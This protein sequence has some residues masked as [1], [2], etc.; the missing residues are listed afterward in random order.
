MH[1][2]R[3]NIAAQIHTFAPPFLH[4]HANLH[5]HTHAFAD[6]HARARVDADA[7]A[8]A[9]TYAHANGLDRAHHRTQ[10]TPTQHHPHAK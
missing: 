10:T 1:A 8:H 7:Q 5:A 9:R 2:T 4:A 6:V 3:T